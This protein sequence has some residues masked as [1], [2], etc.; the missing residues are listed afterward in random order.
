MAKANGLNPDEFPALRRQPDEPEDLEELE[1]TMEYGHKYNLAMEAEMGIELVLNK[2]NF[3][4]ERML[5]ILSNAIYG[6]TV[7]KDDVDENGNISVSY[8]YPGNMVVSTCTRGDFKDM[9][10]V[11]QLADVPISYLATK[12][13]KES[14]EIISNTAQC[15]GSYTTKGMHREA[16]PDSF[17][18]KVLDVE[19]KSWNT[20]SYKNIVTRAGN[21]LTR[22]MDKIVQGPGA[23]LK[24][25]G[26]DIPQYENATQEVIYKGKWIIG[27]DYIY[28]YGLATNMKRS[29]PNRAKVDFSY[30]IY[31]PNFHNMMA[32]SKMDQL[33]PIID[34][35]VTT[36]YKIQNFKKNWVPYLIDIDFDA[37]ERISFGKSGNVMTKKEILDLLFQKFILPNRR[38]DIAGNNINYKAV[39]IRTTGMHQEFLVLVQDLAR[40]ISEMRDTIGLNDLTDGT[41]PNPNILNGV[42]SLG[43]EATNNALRP[44]IDTDSVLVESVAQG[45]I[46]RLVTVV[47]EHKIE[48]LLP[49]LGSNSM[50]FFQVTPDIAMHDWGIKIEN[51]P[52]NLERKEF[53]D[54]LKIRDANGL[55]NPDDYVIINT[56]T[57]L[58][59]AG[60][61][62]AQRLIK[63]KKQA[64]QFA[65]AQ[66][67]MNGKTQ[68][69]SARISE[70]E[71]RKTQLEAHRQ[72][73]EQIEL[74]KRW[75]FDIAKEKNRN[76]AAQKEMDV[77]TKF[78]TEIMRNQASSSA[79][80]TNDQ[81]L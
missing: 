11:G 64:D 65:L 29:R 72:K 9:R 58:K 61:L 73:L 22:R 24:Y 67:E 44:L 8:C 16:T 80:V 47:K 34:E 55:L 21:R 17:N 37:L 46:R 68:Q 56:C 42:A 76:Q 5:G 49:A 32:V 62:L 39:D 36:I 28:D 66:I 41:S 74:E 70:E 1:M 20:R 45:V 23:T 6:V 75:D 79:N 60:A 15:T 50:R 78:A 31:A 3:A 52:T 63:R 18:V 7:Y 38:K 43:V 35:Y 71:K 25:Q 59:Q 40:L 33:K 30:H 4:A 77:T 19:F 53:I 10:Y 27:T 12:F 69:D 48:G 51:R 26:K 57:N 2:N 81:A 54:Q 13:S 14:L